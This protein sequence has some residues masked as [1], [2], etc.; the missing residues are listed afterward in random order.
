MHRILTVLAVAIAA[1]ALSVGATTASAAD[2][3]PL[4]DAIAAKLGVTPDQ[5]RAAVKAA[6]VARVDAALAAGKL[7]PEQAARLKARIAKANG[8]GLG[9]GA[10]K[11]FAKKQKAFGDR[12]A[13]RAKA[14]GPAAAYLGLTREALRAELRKGQSLAQIARA[15]GK[16][17]DGLVAAMVAPLKKRLDKAV[18]NERLTRQ[19]AGAF[20]ERVTNRVERL[21]QRTHAPRAS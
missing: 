9:L 8:F 21:V 14:P 17:V 15:R 16:S 5:L 10:G 2:R 11:A 6:V 19:R 13:K 3:A 20:L 12:L 7:T 1:M 18:A 4:V